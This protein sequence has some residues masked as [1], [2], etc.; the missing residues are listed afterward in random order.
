MF[1]RASFARGK[2]LQCNEICRRPSTESSGQMARLWKNV[3]ILAAAGGGTFERGNPTATLAFSMEFVAWRAGFLT[4]RPLKRNPMAF[5]WR[6]QREFAII[7]HRF[8][9]TPRDKFLS[10]F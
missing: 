5:L 7:P 1:V 2:V 4:A 6:L 10:P 3:E 8:S 9:A